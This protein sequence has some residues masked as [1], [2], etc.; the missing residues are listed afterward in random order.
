MPSIVEKKKTRYITTVSDVVGT[1]RD[2][3]RLGDVAGG[4]LLE[5]ALYWACPITN[6]HPLLLAIG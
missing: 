1:L 3:D 6:H 4:D 5:G 2:G